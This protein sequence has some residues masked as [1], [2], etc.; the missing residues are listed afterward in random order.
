MIEK[1]FLKLWSYPNL[2]NK[3]RKELCDLLVVC[4]DV[5]VIF[6]DKYINFGSL[7]EMTIQA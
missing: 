6:S 4:G 1:S 2:Y 5:A 3:N 7:F